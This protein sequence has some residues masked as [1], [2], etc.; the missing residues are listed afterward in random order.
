MKT[1][2]P[3]LSQ[4]KR[5]LK[6]I[7]HSH[8]QWKGRIILAGALILIALGIIGY[9]VVLLFNHPTT[10]FG[11]FIFL[12]VGICLACVPFFI[13]LS[14]KNT[15]KYKCALPYTSYANGSLL[16]DEDKLEYAFW[17]VG[18]REPAAYSS[19]RA[20]Y[21]DEDKF[22][23]SIK[24][25]EINSLNFSGDICRI[26]GYGI[27]QMPEWAEEDATVK[28]NNKEFSFIMAFDQNNAKDI[29]EEWRK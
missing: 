26:K 10:T 7:S 4:R 21:K 2:S 25:A 27:V 18:P 1:L 3:D 23:Y 13:A 8:P 14:V 28:R 9:T 24:K 15:A 29:I 17:R 16:L 12:C 5:I 11:I 20:V 19:K 22:V 6:T